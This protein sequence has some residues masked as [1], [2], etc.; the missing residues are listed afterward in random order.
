MAILGKIRS[1]SWLLIGFVAVALLLFLIPFDSIQQMGSGNRNEVGSVNGDVITTADYQTTLDQIQQQGGGDQ[2]HDQVWDQL[3][4]DKIAEKRFNKLGLKITDELF[5]ASVKSQGITKELIEELKQN[6]ETATRALLFER[7]R[8]LKEYEL[9]SSQYF[10]FLNSSILANNLEVSL[11]KKANTE[12]ADI[13]YVKVD[14]ESYNS[15]NP[16]KVTDEDLQKY[17]DKHKVKFKRPATRNF[18]YSYF[19]NLPSASDLT[20]SNANIQSFLNG[21]V[22]KDETG[23]II[24]SVQAFKST[25]GDSLYVATYSAMPYFGKFASYNEIEN[26]IFGKDV[27]TWA[28]SAA[29]GQ[30]YG[31]YKRTEKGR[32]YDFLTKLVDKKLSDSIQSRHI[33]IDFKEVNPKAKLT[34]KQASVLADSIV[35]AISS[36]SLLFDK[37]ALKYSVDTASKTKGGD[38]GFSSENYPKMPKEYQ[39]YIQRSNTKSL[40]KIETQY[41]YHLINVTKKIPVPPMKLKLM[42]L[43][44]QVI[45]SE[46]SSNEVFQKASGFFNEI[47]GKKLQDFVNTAISKKYQQKEVK[48]AKRFSV[49]DGLGTDKDEEIL[50]WA[51]SKDTNVGD[52]NIFKTG[53]EDYIVVYLNG[54]F[55]EGT[56]VPSAVRSE[57]EILVRNEILANKIAEKINSNKKTLDQY[58]KEFGSKKESTSVNFLNAAINGVRE[59]KVGGA[60]FGVKQNT[61]S[62]AIKG[63]AAVYVLVTKKLNQVSLPTS[64][65][66]QELMLVEGKNKQAAVGLIKKSLVDD[67]NVKDKRTNVYK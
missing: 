7:N 27:A 39:E 46:N 6:P 33:L 5:W 17:I 21:G 50:K 38:V 35:K 34:K 44:R 55:D 3:V 14:F 66:K 1:M 18:Y 67:A 22:V 12:T 63:N 61:V 23:E 9:V 37:M 45:P 56:A 59:P 51:F 65:A 36:N 11:L 2:A 57:I 41:G 47:K 8:K 19:K 58:A 26:S 30:V 52:T 20:I 40:D 43:V 28:K 53:Y 31:P 48:N 32:S 54:T 60:A 4:M 15:K 29:I 62:K 64:D 49:I 42:N 10:G 24:D 16:Y 25:K 13:D